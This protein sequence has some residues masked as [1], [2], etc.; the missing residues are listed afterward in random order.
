MGDCVINLERTVESFIL[1]HSLLQASAGPVVVGLSGGADSVALLAIL[2]ALKY[3]CIAFH[4]NFHLRGAESD[5]DMEHARRV[6][7]QL[8]AEWH[9]EHF[10]IAGWRSRY[11][12]SVEM[13]C[14]DSRYEAFGR[15]RQQRGA[16]AIAVAHHREDNI[17]TVLHNMMRGTGIA[18]LSGMDPERDHIVRPMLCVS[19]RD[20]EDYLSARGFSFV[21]DSTNLQN[22][23]ARN[24]IR[25]IVV[26]AMVQAN[27]SAVRGIEQTIMRMRET[28]RV[29]RR[30]MRQTVERS[31]R[32][33]G[34]D[35]R[36]L[37]AAYDGALAL[38]EYLRDKGVSRRMADDMIAGCGCSGRFFESSGYRWLNDHGILRE[39]SDDTD[40]GIDFPFVVERIG[41]AD[42][43]VDRNSN[44]PAYF[45]GSVLDKGLDWRYWTEGDRM[46]PYGMK[47]SKK[48]SDLFRDAHV[49]VDRKKNIPL[50]V[51]GAGE[52]LF[53]PGVR[54]SG[55]YPVS[56]DSQVI[57]RISLRLER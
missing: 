56:G 32:D 17:E 12:G 55:L 27:S 34:I 28:E 38:Y 21:T 52:I 20:I 6:A 19:R 48:L 53:V 57:V 50:L 2:T 23:Y 8:G 24:R 1:R 10:D 18:G 39:S 3:D 5:R 40:R 51:S 44:D 11:G 41:R 36:I 46:K 26:P 29:Y 9:E 35:L 45:D 42:F 31:I 33:G 25:N 22:D 54:A 4:C 49:P 43:V 15:L 47:G 14:R 30:V 37:A 7:R 13:A 16:Q